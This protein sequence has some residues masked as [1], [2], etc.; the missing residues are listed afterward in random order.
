MAFK[1]KY[2]QMLIKSVLI[3][4][5]LKLDIIYASEGKHS[6][7]EI[8]ESQMEIITL[9]NNNSIQEPRYVSSETIDS[10]KRTISCSSIFSLVLSAISLTGLFTF[11]A[12]FMNFLLRYFG[13]ELLSKYTETIEGKIVYY[14]GLVISSLF[15]SV[16]FIVIVSDNPPCSE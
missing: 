16:F 1:M 14:I 11:V 15:L 9:A 3:L 10:N 13:S 2:F 8:D 12:F 4:Q 6:Y 7:C 5:L